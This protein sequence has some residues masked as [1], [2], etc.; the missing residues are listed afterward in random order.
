MYST[1]LV[2]ISVVFEHLPDFDVYLSQYLCATSSISTSA[3]QSNKKWD[4]V[5]GHTGRVQP[6]EEL[7]GDPSLAHYPLALLLPLFSCTAFE[8]VAEFLSETDH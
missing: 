3:L 2:S 1:Y 4:K 6:R 5:Q 8:T 7:N